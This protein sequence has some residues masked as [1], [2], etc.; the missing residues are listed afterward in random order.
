MR[1]VAV[2]TYGLPFY[3]GWGLT[4]DLYTFERRK[5]VLT[6]DELCYQ[7]LIS[8]PRYVHWNTRKITSPESIVNAI[9]LE[10]GSLKKLKTSW[11]SRQLRKL[12]YL[13]ET[14]LNVSP[15]VFRAGRS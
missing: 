5:S 3:A 1:G 13:A 4:E 6:L 2:S 12:G 9:A 10:R 8:Y 11:F 7:A 14:I 15:S